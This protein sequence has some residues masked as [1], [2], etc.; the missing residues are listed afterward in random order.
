MRKPIHPVLAVYPGKAPVS[1]MQAL[2]DSPNDGKHQFDFAKVQITPQNFTQW[3]PEI[4]ESFAAQYP[5]TQFRFH[6]SVRLGNYE[7]GNPRHAWFDLAKFI[8]YPKQGKA[9]FKALAEC[10]EVLGNPI[11]SF[12]TGHRLAHRDSIDRLARAFSE[13]QDI[14]GCQCAIETLYPVAAKPKMN[15]IDCWAEHEALLNCGIPFVLDLS[16]INI[17]A[18]H[19]GRNDAL[20]NE[21][22]ASPNLIEIHLSG[23]DGLAD[24]HASLE[25][26]EGEWWWPL[27][28]AY[29]GEADVFSEGNLKHSQAKVA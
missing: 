10:N 2:L 28:E 3:T 25:S 4:T 15:W 16:H 27:V 9:Y 26:C 7:Y 17:I 11:Y 29:D 19:E 12:H 13:I 8:A 24:S 22:L 20:V 23:N 14:M 1:A 18:H 6:A 21:M 5:K